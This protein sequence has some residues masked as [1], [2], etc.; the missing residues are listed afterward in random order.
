MHGHRVRLEAERKY[1]HLWTDISVG[2][3]YGAIKR[4]AA[5]GLLTEVRSESQ[6]KRPVRQLYAI[7]E[8]GRDALAE[9]RS[10]GLKDIWFKFDPFDLSLT[11]TDP[12]QLDLLPITIANRLAAVRELLERTQVVNENARPHLTLSEE[13]ALSHS[14]YRLQAEV[15]WLEDLIDAMPEIIADKRAPRPTL[16]SEREA[17]DD[18]E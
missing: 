5:E 15:R 1:V 11:S 9:L 16:P 6:G 4:L 8:L 7:T 14:D 17:S 10:H 3:V 13:W 18:E 2:A 12:G